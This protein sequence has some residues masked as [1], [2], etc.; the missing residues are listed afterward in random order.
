[1]PAQILQGTLDL[2]ILRTLSTMGPQHAYGIAN[3]LQQISDDSLNLNQ[4]T[5]YPALIRL[6][7]YGWTR[8]AWS[9]T[10]NNREAKYYTITKAGLK[11]LEEETARWRQMSAVVEKL[12]TEEK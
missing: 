7:Q 9:R 2:M 4:G 8:G 11:A 12:L 5:I 6:E 3:R 1:M 10:E